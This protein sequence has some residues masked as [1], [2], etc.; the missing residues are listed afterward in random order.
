MNVSYAVFLRS[1][2]SVDFSLPEQVEHKIDVVRE[3]VPEDCKVT[4]V[5]HS[6][7]CLMALEVAHRLRGRWKIGTTRMLFPMMMKMR[8]TPNGDFAHLHVSGRTKS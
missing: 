1:G 3:L 7:G 5:G 8:Q 6:V 2:F 4:L